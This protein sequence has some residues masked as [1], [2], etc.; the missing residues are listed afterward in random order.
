MEPYLL[1][2]SEVE[3]EPAG[4]LPAEVALL[5]VEVFGAALSDIYFSYFP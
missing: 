2:E 4:G 1:E 3:V 5:A